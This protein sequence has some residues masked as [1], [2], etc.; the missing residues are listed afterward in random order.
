MIVISMNI[1]VLMQAIGLS[2]V[3]LH[4]TSSIA[5]L[6]SLKST[7]QISRRNEHIIIMDSKVKR[8]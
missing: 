3:I 6:G 8:D 1:S 4:L 2:K 7:H 5:T